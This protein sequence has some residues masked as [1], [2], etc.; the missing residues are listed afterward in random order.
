M[1]IIGLICEYN[2]FHNGHMYHIQKIKELY[3]DS[4]LILVLNGYFLQ[5][6][7]V[8]ILTKEDKTKLSLEFGVDIV[9]EL[10]FLYGT[11]SADIFAEKAI[12]ILNHFHVDTLVFGSESNDI[13][14]IKRI[15]QHQ[16]EDSHYDVQVQL[17]LQEGV[18]YPT[19]MA[20][21]LNQKDFFFLPNDLLAISYTKAILKNH[22]AI[23]PIAI[24]RTNEY[25]DVLSDEHIVSASNI[26]EKL[27][28]KQNIDKYLPS[29]SQKRIIQ[30]N[31]SLLFLLLK[32]K[33]LTDT[34]LS[35]Y[36]DVDECIEY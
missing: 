31:Y 23:E 25:K 8:S 21:A 2:P 6:G 3:P 13:E 32:Y 16:L 11:Q 19:A 17:F 35:A 30:P 27:K 14:Q 24:K 7:D 12:T 9:L 4:L 18:N 33:I 34:H 26:R 22:Y 29:L 10:P 15:A 5:R 28:N 1:K 20:K 36:L